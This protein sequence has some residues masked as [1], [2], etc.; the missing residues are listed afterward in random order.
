MDNY[1]ERLREN[2]LKL[3]PRRKAIVELFIYC[4]SHLTPEEVWNELRKD[5]DQCGL[6]S[7]YRNL[8]SLANC[9]ILTRIQQFDRKK[10]YGLCSAVN[11]GYHHHHITCIKCGKV[12]EIN[13]CAIND[14]KKIN[15][16]RVVS[17][18]MQVNG[19]CD[20]CFK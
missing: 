7:V 1:L 14:T 8:E 12:D 15:G 2:G 6:P 18:F 13:D 10:H 4:D 5:F 20:A 9:G 16:Y 3:T 11:S 17:H 19:I